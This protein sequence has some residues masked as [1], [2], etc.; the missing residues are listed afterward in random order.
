MARLEL[1]GVTL[2]ARL[3][4]Y[5]RGELD[6]PAETPC[7]LW[8]DSLICIGWLKSLSLTLPL[9]VKNRV[10]EVRKFD[11]LRIG[12]VK[13]TKQPLTST[14]WPYHP[15][16]IPQFQVDAVM[17]VCMQPQPVVDLSRFSRLKRALRATA[18]AL[19]FIAYCGQNKQTN[20]TGL[21][22][23]TLGLLHT[24]GVLPAE[25][26]AQK[27]LNFHPCHRYIEKGSYNSA[28]SHIQG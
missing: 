5:V 28:L 13:G 3:L 24:I 27:C 15:E 21:C 17:S 1:V 10:K 26:I 11:D 7:Y 23:M 14:E 4:Q 6:L 18:Y 12:H 2:G 25:S 19:R 20:L 16:K 22:S 8:T 9:F